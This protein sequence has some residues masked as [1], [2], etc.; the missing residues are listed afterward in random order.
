VLKMKPPS[1]LKLAAILTAAMFA[2]VRARAAEFYVATDGNDGSLGT[3]TQP[4]ASLARAQQAAS[5]GDTVWIRGGQ[6]NFSGNTASIG[7][8]FDKSGTSGHPINYFAYQNETPTFDFFNLTTVARIKGFDVTGSYLHF[9]GL[10]LRG[11]QQIITTV[12]ESWCIRVESNGSNNVFEQLNLHNNEGPG[13]FIADGGNNLV[14]NCDSHHNYDPDRGG[15]N[16][17]GFGSHSNDPGNTFIG[18]RAWSNSDDGY[19]FINS[20][21]VA[22]V[23]NSWSFKN[24]FVPDTTT[25]AGNGAGFKAGGFLLDPTKFP[26]VIPSHVLTGN[27][28]FGN[29]TQGFYANHH[30]GGLVFENN[31]AIGN[32]KGFDLLAD[33]DPATYPAHH[34]LRNNI[35]YGNTTDLANATMA[36]INSAN[37]TWD[38]GVSVSNADFLSLISAGMDG[39]RQAD[40]SLPVNPFM[41]LVW[42]SD[43][44]NA[45]VDVGLP[46]HYTAPDLGAFEAGLPGD[47]N[48]D[49]KVDIMDLLALAQHYNST[50]ANWTTGDFNF[51]GAVNGADLAMLAGNW[52]TNASLSLNAAL[53][54]L[55]LPQSEVPEPG[56]VGVSLLAY[57]AVRRRRPLRRIAGTDSLREIQRIQPPGPP[58][59]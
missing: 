20:P 44:I 2:P 32:P 58:V 48:Y 57:C 29:R 13:L 55:G 46:F 5:P 40:G 3:F 45:G 49:G 26:A 52:Q 53:S 56:V 59:H 17:D 38:G 14:L 42:G 23:R 12:N 41:Q 9:K 4:F 18:D 47:A 8:L 16:A 15:G 33:V 19:D 24:G 6:Y 34:F 36:D 50:G 11:V 31:T 35:S 37:N 54:A 22:T 43:L 21:G 28:A 27:L 10:E 25:P 39:P 51:D 7:V 30:P 1:H